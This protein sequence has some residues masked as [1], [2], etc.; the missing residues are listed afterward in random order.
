MILRMLKATGPLLGVP[1]WS[2]RGVH[3]DDGAKDGS[4]EATEERK[5]AR[6]R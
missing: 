3:E 2:D 5:S 6:S 1:D 4:S